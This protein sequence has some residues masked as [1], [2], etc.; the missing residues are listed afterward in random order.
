M[1]RLWFAVAAC[2]SLFVLPG[3]ADAEVVMTPMTGNPI[4]DTG[5]G[6]VIKAVDL[7]SDGFDDLV[8][9]SG[10]AATGGAH[11]RLAEPDG[12]WTAKP[13]LAA[14]SPV[15]E[16]TSGDFNG[17]DKPD[18]LLNLPDPANPLGASGSFRVFIG[19]GDGTFNPGQTLTLPGDKV[20]AVPPT[21]QS[22]HLG[23]INDDDLP[24]LW[25]GLTH[26][27]FG[28]ARGEG[29]G[30][31]S[32]LGVA[33]FPDAPTG[34]LEGFGPITEGDF[35]GDGQHDFVLGLSGNGAGSSTEDDSGFFVLYGR[36][37]ASYEEPLHVGM[38]PPYGPVTR[39]IARD[40]SGDGNDDLILHTTADGALTSRILIYP[41][42][43]EGFGTVPAVLFSI[44]MPASTVAGADFNSDGKLDLGWV[45]QLGVVAGNPRPNNLRIATGGSDGAFSLQ[46]T[47]FDLNFAG[48]KGTASMTAAGDFNG[49]G[50]TDLAAPFNSTDCSIQGCGTTVLFNR[51]VVSASQTEI[52]FGTVQQGSTPINQQF[53]LANEGGAPAKAKTLFLSGT[54]PLRFSLAGNCQTI[55]PA[56]NCSPTI[57]FDRSTV[58]TWTGDI[59][60]SYEGL[61]DPVHLTLTGTVKEPPS[62]PL[63]YKAALKLAGP[64]KVKAGKKFK[65]KATV[66]STGTGSLA[67]ATLN[68]KATQGK[69]KKAT[70]K[71]KLGQIKP[72]GKLT[73]AIPIAIKKSKLARGKPVKV[74]VTVIRQNKPLASKGFSVKQEFGPTRPDKRK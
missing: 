49:D 44:G 46:A 34:D 20:V 5:Q 42:G 6:G 60:I 43:P 61:A 9:G 37:G 22:M 41:G 66:T 25:V 23:L 10:E 74:T 62:P 38:L 11:I 14:G 52:D 30:T 29:D 48:S 72:G 53:T 51:P 1:F 26:G 50:A 65:V 36:G 33:N 12:S 57:S 24:D 64:K 31:F 2:A 13:T 15:G 4:S 18:L 70:G 56:G 73:R 58:G 59:Q 45:E 55:V 8:I 32:A 71:L 35:N 21:G 69:A 3:L 68:Y 67:G 19:A 17:D 47:A 39:L 40:I 27:Q 7:D 16:I 63:T 54:E 28:I